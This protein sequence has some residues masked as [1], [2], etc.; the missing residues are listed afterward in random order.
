MCGAY[1]MT[2]EE[3]DEDESEISEQLITPD[4]N[5]RTFKLTHSHSYIH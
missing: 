4:L 1:Q 5:G 3:Q 2:S